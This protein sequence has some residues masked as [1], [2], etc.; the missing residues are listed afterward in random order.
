MLLKGEENEVGMSDYR[1]VTFSLIM[2]L[3]H[4]EN[5]VDIRPLI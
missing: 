3:L 1:K 4:L 2:D 5:L